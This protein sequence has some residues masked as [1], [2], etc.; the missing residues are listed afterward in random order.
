[1][2]TDDLL[3][4]LPYLR[5]HARMLT[6]SSRIGDD[7]VRLCLELL[8]DKPDVL[9][10]DDA[11]LL[12]YK[13]FHKMWAAV[14]RKL[15]NL[16]IDEVSPN[17]AASF[18]P[19]LRNLASFERRVVLLADV[20][21]FAKDE[22]AVILKASKARIEACLA[23]AA[24]TGSDRTG[25]EVLIIEDDPIIAADI[26]NV[27]RDMGFA[28]I[29]PAGNEEQAAALFESHSPE[30]ILSDVQLED[31]DSGIAATWRI[32]KDSNL[33]VIFVTGFPQAILTGQGAEPA[34]VLAKPFSPNGLRSTID[35][36]LD[37]YAR[38]ELAKQHG[39]HLFAHLD[40]IMN[41][42][43]LASLIEHDE[44]RTAGDDD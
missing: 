22:I 44:A 42:D 38:P 28:I 8:I 5:R 14:A 26:A 32:L 25:K 24:A 40:K 7:Y 3:P 6:G 4:H 18:E 31:D 33:P 20:E 11:R 39:H 9:Q 21:G 43:A 23:E 19:L 36:V 13:A 29:G 30:L 15:E 37:I 17:E 35:Q 41:M 34:F 16:L 12:L 2:K 27:L 10:G 1:M